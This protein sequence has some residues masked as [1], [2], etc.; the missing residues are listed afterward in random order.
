[1]KLRLKTAAFSFLFLC[2][3][4]IIVTFLIL[5]LVNSEAEGY[6]QIDKKELDTS[7]AFVFIPNLVLACGN[8][9]FD[10]LFSIPLTIVC[11]FYV[12]SQAYQNDAEGNLGCFIGAETYASRLG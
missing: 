12:T 2:G 7:I 8:W 3:V 11:Q 9:K 6:D 5:H 10:L 4:R 1:M